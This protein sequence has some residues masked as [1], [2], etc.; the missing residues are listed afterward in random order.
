MSRIAIIGLACLFPGAPNLAAFW[1]NIVD[2]V[3]AIGEVPAGRWDADFYDPDSKEI[4]RFYCKRGGFVDQHAQFDPLVFGVVPKAA[5][6]GE[7]DQLLTLRVGYQ[8]L[9][10]AGYAQREFSRARTGVIIGRGNYIGA[11]V[12]RLQQHVRMLPQIVQTLRDLFPDLG[13]DALAEVRAKLQQQ[14]DYYGPDVA[15]GMIPNLLASRLAN[16]LDLRGPA[17]TIDAACASSLIAVEQA[18]ASLARGETDLMLAGGA[19]LTHDLTFWATF[20]QLGALSRSGVVRPLSADADGILAG[21]GVGMSVLKRLDDAIRDGDRIYAVIEGVGSSSDGRSG[22]LVSP[23]VS[24]Q[25]LALQK[26]WSGLPFAREEIGLVEAHGTGTPAGDGV[27]LETLAGFFGTHSGDKTRP[28]IGSVKSMIGHAMPASGMASLIKTALAVY[29]GVLPPTLHCDMPHP[30]LAATRFRTIAKS[31]PWTAAREQRIAALNAFGFGGI[32]AHVVLRGLPQPALAN[33]ALAELPPALMLSAQTPQALLERLDAGDNDVASPQP[34]RCRL[35]IVAPDQK[36]LA[37]A[38]KAIASGKAW[39]GRQQ[40]WFS[41]DGLLSGTNGKLVFVFPGVDSS[42]QPQAS[43]LPA[44]FGR[45]LPPFC[46]ALDPAQSL[47]RVVVGL[48]GFNRYLFDCLSDMGIQAQAYAGH[49]VG[50][51]SAMLCAGMMDQALSERTNAELDFDAVKFPDVQFL[52]ASCDEARLQAALADLDGIALSHDNCP[53]QVIACGARDAIAIVAGRLHQAGIF[54][55]VLPFVSGFHSPL[56]ADHMDWYRAFFGAAEL[57]EP[58][59]PVWSATTVAPFP[60]TMAAKRQLALDHLLQPVRFRSL[61]SRLYDEGCRVFVEVGTGSLTGFIDDTLTGQPHIALRTNH[62]NRSGLA[63]LQQLCAALWVE[64]AVFDTRLLTA[65]KSEIKTAAKADITVDIKTGLPVEV[66]ASASTRTL[67]LG[68]P[69]VRLREPLNAS[70]LPARWSS[71]ARSELPALASN[72]A[73]GRLIRDTLFDIERAGRDVLELWQRHRSGSSDAGMKTTAPP[74]AAAVLP[75]S[76]HR[77]LDIERT[78]PY[79]CDHELYPQRPGWPIVADRHP[80]VPMTMEVMLVREAVEETLP[81]LKVIEVAQIQAY[82]WLA[83]S[84]PVNVEI[85]LASIE[86]DVVEAEIVGYFKARVR[87]AEN[88][89]LPDL[90]APA[91]LIN[92]HATA[93]SPDALYRD[94][95]MFHGPAYQG[96][97]DFKAIGDNGIDGELQVPAGKGALLDNMGQLAGYWVMEQPSDCLAMP[98]G[99]DCIRFFAPD[100]APG[101]RMQAS[102]RIVQLDALNCVSHHQLRNATG[103]LS[104]AIEGWRTRRYQMDKAFWEASRMLSRYSVSQAVPG[105]V[106]LFD[107]RYDTAILRDYISRRYLTASERATYDT[108]SP[109]RRRQWLAGRVAAKDAVRNY[110]RDRSAIEAPRRQ[111]SSVEPRGLEPIYPQE[112]LIENDAAGAPKVRSNVTDVV[113][114]ALQVSIA[115]KGTLAAAIVGEQSVGIDLERVEPRDANFVSLVFN[116]AECALLRDDEDDDSAYTRGWVV[117]EAAAKAAGTGLGGRLRDFVIDARDGDCLRVNGRWVV[118]HKLPGYIVGWTLDSPAQ[119]PHE[120]TAPAAVASIASAQN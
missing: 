116:D 67:A 19:H 102:V 65:A 96:V 106:V 94:G 95:W 46:E 32:N 53:H 77:L 58:K 110:L 86:P 21:E 100:A 15:A 64:G 79:V 112:V 11:G 38:R 91:E 54:A 99:V 88:Y 39:Q 66:A 61:I 7:P 35:L 16:R 44:Y 114:Q 33:A 60:P 10:D 2:G 50:E 69:L 18:C 52:A 83:V 26:A 71:G 14:F 108:L 48:L 4:D 84:Q 105:N 76:I 27:E 45:P 29:H 72:D 109:K 43:D 78:I 111:S 62:A 107:D 28:V 1:R 75:R 8:A 3:D 68:V 5:E 87:V 80:V 101:E 17:F 13:D 115:H 74:A 34:G 20:C 90:P 37:T 92:P 82:N 63:Q 89:P 117:K 24:G 40:I 36:K 6:V 85:T 30:R 25:T 98:I 70:L 118:T 104:I 120:N 103:A 56:F 42:F 93:I 49:S 22:S 47:S 97:V 57:V 59:V 23:S 119:M 55:S 113:P 12:L 51:W 31:E 73:V 41:P 9:D 81:A